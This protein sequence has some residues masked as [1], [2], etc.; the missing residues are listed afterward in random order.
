MNENTLNADLLHHTQCGWV[1]KSLHDLSY[2]PI[3]LGPLAYFEGE[4]TDK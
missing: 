4:Q 1:T 2:Y 3:H